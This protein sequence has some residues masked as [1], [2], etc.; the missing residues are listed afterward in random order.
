M[1]ATGVLAVRAVLDPVSFPPHLASASFLSAVKFLHLSVPYLVQTATPQ[2][3]S[4][5]L[6][7]LRSWKRIRIP[8]PGAE[9]LAHLGSG[10]QPLVQ[11]T[12]VV[13]TGTFRKDKVYLQRVQGNSLPRLKQ[14]R[15]QKNPHKYLKE[16][17]LKLQRL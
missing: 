12:T 10:V 17:K 1:E 7:G 4:S 13:K 15:K 8:I 5:H 11:S 6:P 2:P 14:K 9:N 3:S 16:K